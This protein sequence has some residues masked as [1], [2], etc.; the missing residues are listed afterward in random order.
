LLVSAILSIY[1]KET[2]IGSY[3]YDVTSAE[4]LASII[5]HLFTMGTFVFCFL[6]AFLADSC[7]GKYRLA[8]AFL[9][10][11]SQAIAKISHFWKCLEF[12]QMP[13]Q[14]REVLY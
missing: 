5:F 3:N 6:G 9:M 2:L 7:I 8:V 14:F 13:R 1:L 11:M 4:N 12:L 10:H